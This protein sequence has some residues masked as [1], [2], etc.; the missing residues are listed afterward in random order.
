MFEVL[1]PPVCVG[2]RVLL[3]PGNGDAIEDPVCS[4]CRTEYAPLP[5]DMRR[6][7]SVDACF[8][9]Q[10]ALAQ[11]VARLKFAGD[12]S[13]AG[14]LGRLL[15]RAPT[16]AE[17][18]DLIVPVPLHWRRALGRGY[19]QAHLLAHWALPR[20]ERH[21]LGPRVLVRT[22]HSPAQTELEAA[23]RHA[24]VDGAFRVRR[25]CRVA[26]RSVLVIDD[27]TTTGSTMRACLS[28][29]RAAGARRAH[30]LALLRTLA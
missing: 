1:F 11:A 21:R 9:Y 24:N 29:L 18:W 28:A 14:P 7:H 3:R 8:A 10:G 4:R 20:R 27:V 6:L 16:L 22:R 26:D 19:N 17:R 2:C 13:V 5:D 30:G 15:A 12:T 23:A 25:P